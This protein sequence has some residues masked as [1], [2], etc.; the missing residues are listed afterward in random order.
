MEV[1]SLGLESRRW[2]LKASV[3][4][5]LDNFGSPELPC[6]KSNSLAGEARWAGKA[7]EPRAEGGGSCLISPDD[8]PITS[9]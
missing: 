8:F 3:F 5:L 9:T 2:G 6:K 7:L 1:M 4:S